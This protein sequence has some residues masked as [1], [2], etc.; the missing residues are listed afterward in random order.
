MPPQARISRQRDVV[1]GREISYCMFE[2]HLLRPNWAF[3]H[4]KYFAVVNACN[5]RHVIPAFAVMISM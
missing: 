1:Y 2:T 3:P 5:R 4:A